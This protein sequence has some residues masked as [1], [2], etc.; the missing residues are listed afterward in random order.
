MIY[1]VHRNCEI[2]A[3]LNVWENERKYQDKINI[4]TKR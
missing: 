4:K 2:I 3:V 1:F